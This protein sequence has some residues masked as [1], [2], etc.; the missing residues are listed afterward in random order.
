MIIAKVVPIVLQY[1]F[2]ISISGDLSFQQKLGFV[3][4]TSNKIYSFKAVDGSKGFRAS[5]RVSISGKKFKLGYG[6]R[7]WIE[8][9]FRVSY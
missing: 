2:S 3:I 9:R 4:R 5:L 8:D 1:H 7:F 6:L